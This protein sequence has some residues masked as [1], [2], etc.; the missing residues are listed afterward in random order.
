[1]LSGLLPQTLVPNIKAPLLLHFAAHDKR[2][3][4]GW[5]DYAKA[6]QEKAADAG[7]RVYSRTAKKAGKII[8]KVLVG[9]KLDKTSAEK[10]KLEVEKKL[11]TKSFLVDYKPSDQ[12]YR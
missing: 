5:P 3:N 7:F 2:V 10:L 9:P 8:T 4:A 12:F 6:L 11:G 1:M